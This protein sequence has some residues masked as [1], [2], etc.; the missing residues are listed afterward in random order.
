MTRAHRR[1]LA[2]LACLALA[3]LAGASL[4]VAGASGAS[5]SASLFTPDK[6]NFKILVSGQQA[7]KEA[8]ELSS[9]GGD[10]VV[11]GNSEIQSTDG[12]THVS[13]TLQLHADGTP[14]SYEWST[15][16]PKK[17]SSTITFA[18]PVAT[19]E[20]RLEGRRPFTQQFTF[21]SP[22]IVVLDNN[23]YYQ[24]AVL[25]GLYDREKKGLQTFSVLVPQELTPGSVTVQSLGEQ[26]SNG[27]KKLEELV[28][29]TEDLEVDLFLDGARLVR[30]VAP[31]SNAEIVRQ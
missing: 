14:V 24:Y 30:I 13:G 22:Q 15:E 5:K 20:L 10:W 19:I 6:G 9:N 31:S 7:G 4:S 18:G 27:G 2:A 26:N 17:A 3:A 16:G 23:L 8:F 29:K 1:I 28:V 12:V 11:K 25:A 21:N